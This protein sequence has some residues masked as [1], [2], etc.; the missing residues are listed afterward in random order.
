MANHNVP[1]PRKPA[2]SSSPTS[3]RFSDSTTDRLRAFA[4]KGPLSAA[5]LMEFATNHL[6]DEME[7][8]ATIH[9]GADGLKLVRPAPSKRQ[10]PS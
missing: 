1:A 7:A 10:R 6:F 9:L 3:V 5:Q 8:G 2:R 4:A